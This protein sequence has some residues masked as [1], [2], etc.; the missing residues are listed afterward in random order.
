MDL[1]FGY[2]LD[3]YIFYDFFYNVVYWNLYDCIIEKIDD[4]YLVNGRFLVFFYFSGY[5]FKN[6]NKLFKY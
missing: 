1:I 3:M 4:E 2:F 6:R 5:F